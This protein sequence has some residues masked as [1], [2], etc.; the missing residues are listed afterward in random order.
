MEEDRGVVRLSDSFLT[1][2]P[3]MSIDQYEQ[4]L[5][6]L[7]WMQRYIAFWIGDLLNYGE[8]TWGDQAWE[9]AP[10]DA[11]LGMLEKYLGVARKVPRSARNKNLSWS[12]HA[13]ITNLKSKENQRKFLA[14][15]E[16]EALGCHEL[17]AQIVRFKKGFQVNL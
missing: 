1:C 16:R 7:I 5:R 9:V 11:S 15:A 8:Y 2:S 14:L 3:Q 13:E 12:H 17:R 4:E 10:P 6:R